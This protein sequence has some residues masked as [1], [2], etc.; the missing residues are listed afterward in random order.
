M[1]REFSRSRKVFSQAKCFRRDCDL[2]L[3]ALVRVSLH[4][5]ERTRVRLGLHDKPGI[6]CR[7]L[8]ARE[9][10]MK[11]PDETLV[12][13]SRSIYWLIE[14]CG[15]TLDQLTSS[16]IPYHCCTPGSLP[17]ASRRVSRSIQHHPWRT[18]ARPGCM[19]A[20]LRLASGLILFDRVFWATYSLLQRIRREGIRFRDAVEFRLV[21]VKREGLLSNSSTR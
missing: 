5:R 10:S 8:M 21:A 14:D 20:F 19:V 13:A 3:T 18:D 11:I 7:Q 15:I 12:L 6:A 4:D 17:G 9:V 2:L 1:V 16:G